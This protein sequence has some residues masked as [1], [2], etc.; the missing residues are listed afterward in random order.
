MTFQLLIFTDESFPNP[1]L[2]E[3]WYCLGLRNTL[4]SFITVSSGQES[5][6]P[7]SKSLFQFLLGKDVPLF[8]KCLLSTV[9]MLFPPVC[10]DG[11]WPN[12]FH[13]S[14]MSY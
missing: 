6:G 7:W 13:F 3:F 9:S 4:C 14:L 1:R 12:I 2:L 10:E 11:L 5:S 8:V